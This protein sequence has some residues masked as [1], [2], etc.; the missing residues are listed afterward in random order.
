MDWLCFEKYFLCGILPAFPLKDALRIA[1][2][3]HLHDRGR[4]TDFR[5]TD[6]QMKML[7]HD[8][9]SQHDKAIAHPRLFQNAQEQIAP[10]GAIEPPMALITAASD[11]VQVAV[12][13]E[14]F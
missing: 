5:F 9:V 14:A 3:K 6:Q 1:L 8:H 12:M 4:V 2:L 11:E 7:G 10:P 13:I